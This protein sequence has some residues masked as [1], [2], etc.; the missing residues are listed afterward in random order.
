[1]N[2]TI[3]PKKLIIIYILDILYKYTDAD[4]RLSQRDIQQKLEK[5]Y[6][7]KVDRKAV[8]RNLMDLID[9]GYPIEYTE[10]QRSI[11]NKQTAEYE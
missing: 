1:M 10:T 8:K 4:H 11:L 3:P 7:M 9:F 5:D 2:Y 6:T